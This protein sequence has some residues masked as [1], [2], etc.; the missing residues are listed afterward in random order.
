MACV[1]PPRASSPRL[2]SP[3]GAGLLLHAQAKRLQPKPKNVPRGHDDSLQNQNGIAGR[4][5][6][7][8]RGA[9]CIFPSPISSHDTTTNPKIWAGP[10]F[11]ST[12]AA[13]AGSQRL[14]QRQR[15]RE[16]AREKPSSTLTHTNAAYSAYPLP[17][18]HDLFVWFIPPRLADRSIECPWLPPSQSQSVDNHTCT[19]REIAVWC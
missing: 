10:Y 18:P 5:S 14:S 12:T 4:G 15:E 8:G 11:K 7:G 13:A 6:R 3:R 2:S 1:A 17:P 16:R 9:K 19:H